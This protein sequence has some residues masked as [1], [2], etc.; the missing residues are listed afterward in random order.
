MLL[1]EEINIKYN[2]NRLSRG[3]Q[4]RQISHNFSELFDD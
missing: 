4:N 1:P 2:K 3:L